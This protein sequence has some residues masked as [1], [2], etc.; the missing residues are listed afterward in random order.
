MVSGGGPPRSVFEDEDDGFVR[1]GMQ[2]DPFSPL[3]SPRREG[4]QGLLQVPKVQEVK[5][6][7]VPVLTIYLAMERIEEYGRL[8]GYVGL[9]AAWHF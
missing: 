2:D 7:M 5:K 4:G 6:I 8:Y 9:V 3:A 1:G